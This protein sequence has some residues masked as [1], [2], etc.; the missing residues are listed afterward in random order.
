MRQLNYEEISRLYQEGSYGAVPTLTCSEQGLV[1]TFTPI[2]KSPQFRGQPGAR[3]V[4]IVMP[5]EM[6]CVRTHDDIRAA[7]EGKAD[8]YGVLGLPLLIAVN[9][10]D[11][12]CDDDD[13]RNALFGEEQ[14][15]VIR[16]GVGV[17]RHECNRVPNGAWYGRRGPRND[18]VSGVI[19]SH[20]LLPTTLRVCA[21]ELIH[22][23]WA[24]HPLPPELWPLPQRAISL[25]DGHINLRPGTNAAD[26]LGVPE[27]W[28]VPD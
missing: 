8:K 3:P 9:V 25:P 17:F 19:V 14:V 11:D 16:Q 23:P 27:P 6:H 1:L 20:A 12:F 18:L 4:G 2:P 10:M 28:P 5:T 21:V 24:A 15:V 7:V 26:L 22:N 13:V